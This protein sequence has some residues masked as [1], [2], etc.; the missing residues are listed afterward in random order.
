MIVN[1]CIAVWFVWNLE[2]NSGYLIKQDWRLHRQSNLNQHSL[3]ANREI[4]DLEKPREVQKVKRIEGIDTFLLD[5]ISNPKIIEKLNNEKPENWSNDVAELESFFANVDLPTKPIKLNKS[6]LIR[7][8]NL[9]IESHLATLKANIGKRF[10][11][12]YLERLIELKR[13]L[14]LN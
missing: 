7:D 6:G 12:P 4:C 11:F 2:S 5:E 13:V 8:C 1:K 14:S 3:K 9:F 10:F